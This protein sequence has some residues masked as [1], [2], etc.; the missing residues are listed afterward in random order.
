[1]EVCGPERTSTGMESYEEAREAGNGDSWSPG[2]NEDAS[3]AE[4]KRPC[5]TFLELGIFLPKTR[6]NEAPSYVNT[7]LDGSIYPR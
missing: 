5:K 7:L 6:S 1:M 3:Y 4:R 2:A